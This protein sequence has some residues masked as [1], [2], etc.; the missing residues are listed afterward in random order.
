MTSSFGNYYERTLENSLIAICD[1]GGARQSERRFD[2]R[3]ARREV[4]D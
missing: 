3:Q 4:E 1:S 2:S